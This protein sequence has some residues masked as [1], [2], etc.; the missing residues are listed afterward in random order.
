MPPPP[1]DAAHQSAAARW[2]TAARPL[3][4]EMLHAAPRTVSFHCHGARSREEDCQ[5]L[6]AARCH[7]RRRYQTRNVEDDFR[8]AARIH[9][10]LPSTWRR[11]ARA[12]KIM[13]ASIS[14]R[15]LSP[16]FAPT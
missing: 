1:I 15:R 8:Q 13:P 11:H 3:R 9:C 7:C 14:G 5:R 4:A 16:M 6:Y 10:L 12:F 2:L